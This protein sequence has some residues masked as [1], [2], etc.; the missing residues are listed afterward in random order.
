[1]TPDAMTLDVAALQAFAAST[2]T[3]ATTPFASSASRA[4]FEAGGILV[5][6]DRPAAAKAA[7][8]T[9]RPRWLPKPGGY[10]RDMPGNLPA[11]VLPPQYAGRAWDPWYQYSTSAVYL[12]DT[13]AVELRGSG[14]MPNGTNMQG[15]AHQQLD[16]DPAK[17]RWSWRNVTDRANPDEATNNN[18]GAKRRYQLD[19]S[20]PNGHAYGGLA[21]RPISMGG[22]PDLLQLE[23]ITQVVWS[24]DATKLRYG[25]Q[26]FSNERAKGL[27]GAGAFTDSPPFA[28]MARVELGQHANGVQLV[29][30][31]SLMGW[32]ASDSSGDANVTPFI[33]R[34][35]KLHYD[36]PQVL[37]G[38]TSGV[39]LWDDAHRLL[40]GLKGREDQ[41]PYDT[42]F[43]SIADAK[44]KQVTRVHIEGPKPLT[45]DGKESNPDHGCFKWVPDKDY[46]LGADVGNTTKSP[47]LRFIA[48]RPPKSGDRRTTA[49]TSSYVDLKPDPDAPATDAKALRFIDSGATDMVRWVWVPKYQVGILY[50]Q[51][52]KP[53]QVFT[54]PD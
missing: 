8:A 18:E 49:W 36:F 3:V 13:N 15:T 17:I 24:L 16:D 38:W 5:A 7:P 51:P 46:A 12:R 9:T 33:D 23:S 20:A 44:T 48:V 53:A 4:R 52:G 26:A 31:E 6:E 30:A 32:F 37:G 21:E 2:R 45:A 29:F 28:G 27:V 42:F 19:G 34:E 40:I 35:G 10:F 41:R 47:S 22:A 43:M 54:L 14:H 1:M 25:Y 39:L 11:D 50:A